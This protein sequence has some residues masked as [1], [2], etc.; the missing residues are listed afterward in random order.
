MK[1]DIERPREAVALARLEGWISADEDIQCLTVAGEG[2]MNQTLRAHLG[3]RRV[4]L[5][6]SLPYVARYPDIPAPIERLDTEA[7][8]YALTAT[9]ARLMQHMPTPIGYHRPSHL[10]CLEDL[11]SGSDRTDLYEMRTGNVRD[12]DLPL[13]IAWL[14]HLHKAIPAQGL[15][16]M[17]MRVL[18]HEH[19]FDIP[20]K[21]D[22]GVQIAAEL[23]PFQAELLA[24]D[25][26]RDSAECLGE[27]YLGNRTH[28]STPALLH[29]DFYPGSWLRTDSGGVGVIDF[30]FAFEGPSEYDYGILQAHLTFAGISPA[31]QQALINAVSKPDGF[32]PAL[33]RAFAGMEVI[34]RILGVAQLP[35]TTDVSTLLVW[36]RAAR[37]GVLAW[38]D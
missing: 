5:K 33:A 18:N 31:D 6:Q 16:N 25:N 36:L 14:G 9:D 17:S 3:T 30:E 4:I 20:L 38:H 10:L 19:I 26:L 22:N 7:Q 15:A 32:S 34:R 12:S 35:L 11:G 21:S 28:T 29:G 1:L 8:F 13:L 37:D 24:D 2:N 23:R 27:I